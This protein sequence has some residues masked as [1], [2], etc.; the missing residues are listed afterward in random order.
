MV[1]DT[2]SKQTA[3]QKRANPRAVAKIEIEFKTAMDFAKSYMLN[4][5]NGGLFIKTDEPFSLDSIV[6]LKFVIPGS[7]EPIEAEGKV[8][9][10]NPKG[11]RSYFP[12]GMGIKFVKIKT[13]DAEK[14]MKFVKEHYNEIESHSFL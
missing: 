3:E 10:C 7:T 12:R 1:P 11:G 4:V 13:D 6:V 5:S 9:W 14:I 8:I 2:D